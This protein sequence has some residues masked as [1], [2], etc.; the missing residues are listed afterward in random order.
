MYKKNSFS[1]NEFNMGEIKD[2]LTLL[3]TKSCN[4]R[5]TYCYVD[6]EDLSY[7]MTLNNARDIVEKFKRGRDS[8]KLKVTFFGGEPL[9]NF[10]LIN[11]IVS[12]NKE[13][14]F[15]IIT[16]GTLMDSNVLKFLNENKNVYLII[17]LDAGSSVHDISRIDNCGGGT[18]DKIYN[19]LKIVTKITRNISINVSLNKYTIRDPKGFCEHIEDMMSMGLSCTAYSL[20]SPDSGIDINEYKSFLDYVVNYGGAPKQIVLSPV[21]E[22]GTRFSHTCTIGSSGPIVDNNGDVYMCN[23]I[24]EYESKKDW[25]AG[26]LLDESTS[27]LDICENM[28]RVLEQAS[29]YKNVD[30][31]KCEVGLRYCKVHCPASFIEEHGTCTKPNYKSCELEKILHSYRKLYNK[32]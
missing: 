24:T 10:K 27:H 32:K 26:N 14:T 1:I 8:S 25:C 23:R 7:V 30:C 28:F 13:M 3:L 29:V 6:K 4:L 31:F 19:T 16:N 18:F 21:W 20:K 5:C 2:N 15:T 9:M 22:G 17:S 12:E 11:A